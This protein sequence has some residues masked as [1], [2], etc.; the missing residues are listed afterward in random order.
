MASNSSPLYSSF[1]NHFVQFCLYF[2][3]NETLV[4][5][6]LILLPLPIPLALGYAGTSSYQ[7]GGMTVNIW[8]LIW[9]LSQWYV[10]TAQ[11][12]I[13]SASDGTAPVLSSLSSIHP[14]LISPY[15]NG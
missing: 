13:H 8:K 10:K 7:H 12:E 11:T 9:L 3:L 14:L 15:C 6:L 1:S 5:L 2:L 4:S